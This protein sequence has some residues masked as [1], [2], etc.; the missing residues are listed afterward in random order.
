MGAVAG[1]VLRAPG[2]PTLYLAGDTIWCDEVAAALEAHRPDVVLLNAGA[3]QLLV[4]DPITMTAGDVAAVCRAAP[5]AQVVAVHM[6][7]VNHCRLTRAGLRAALEAA[8]LSARVAIP[9]DG[10]RLR[11]ERAA[12]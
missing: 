1:F 6:D 4:G 5:G 8:G 7:A 9:A 12:A 10:Q 3:A 11:F 2:E